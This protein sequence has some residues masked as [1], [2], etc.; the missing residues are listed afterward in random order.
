MT[1]RFPLQGLLSAAVAVVLLTVIVAPVAAQP[2]GWPL[3]GLPDQ[4][5]TTAAATEY[6]PPADTADPP[7]SPA[8]LAA[9]RCWAAAMAGLGGG[10]CDPRSIPALATQSPENRRLLAC[11]SAALDGDEEACTIGLAPITTPSAAGVAC[12]IERASAGGASRLVC[13]TQ[14]AG[15]TDLPDGC[16]YLQDHWCTSAAGTPREILMEELAGCQQL[17]DDVPLTEVVSVAPGYLRGGPGPLPSTVDMRAN[18]V[19]DRYAKLATLVAPLGWFNS[20]NAPRTSAGFPVTTYHMYHK[21]GGLLTLHRPF[22]G[23]ILSLA[24]Q[25]G[26]VALRVAMWMFDWA[27]SGNVTTIL[28]GIP[29]ELAR[30]LQEKVVRGLHLYELG[31]L[32]L[33][34]TAGWKLLR[35]RVADA[36][37]TVMFALLAFSLG[38]LLLTPV[39]FSG[40]YAGALETRAVLADGLTLGVIADAGSGGLDA[41]AAM[42]VVLDSAVH[43]PWEHLNFGQKLSDPCHIDSAR[44]I[45]ID[46]IRSQAGTDLGA[47]SEC[48]AEGAAMVDFAANPSGE[49]LFGTLIVVLGQFAVAVLVFVAAGL[50]LLSEVLLGAAF[51]SLPL[52]VAGVLWP[53]GRRVAGAWLSL[54]LRGLVGFAVGMLFLS[55]VMTVLAA[56]VGRTQGMALLERSLAFLLVAYG[57]VRLRKVFPLAAAQISAQLGGK[58]SAAFSQRGSGIGGTVGGAAAGGLAGGLAASLLSPRSL[59][60]AARV[61]QRGA[62][63]TLQKVTGLTAA[64]LDAAKATRRNPGRTLQTVATLAAATKGG[65]AAMDQRQAKGLAG[66]AAQMSAVGL[67]RKLAGVNRG[68][69]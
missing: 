36:A 52:A 53:G 50:A 66:T 31:L 12:W 65:R 23:L 20:A 45:L 6:T 37:G 29:G 11:L 7:L 26:L 39:A 22:L 27:T 30:M 17:R 32:L 16:G 49:R 58:V 43:T 38:W 21:T 35:A 57:G 14:L 67:A 2:P 48:G 4:V 62:R 63:G 64:G 10:D 42:Q 55:L 3:E 18:C 69:V 56:V 60:S 34:A 13:P 15:L 44:T 33:A 28:A 40:Y 9:Y 5:P 46:G 68:G 19:R 54:L 24:W 8:E 1:T 61:A 59:S 41:A 47:L 25:A 51:A